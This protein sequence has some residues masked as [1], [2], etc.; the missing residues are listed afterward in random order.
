VVVLGLLLRVVGIHLAVI[1]GF[2]GTGGSGKT[3]RATH[4]VIEAA[5][6][7]PVG[8]IANF[9]VKKAGNPKRWNC[10]YWPHISP[11]G[12]ISAAEEW[13]EDERE[14]LCLVVVDESERY[15]QPRDWNRKGV[16]GP[17]SHARRAIE[18]AGLPWSWYSYKSYA[19]LRSDWIELLAMHR[20]LGFDFIF[21][22]PTKKMIDR[23]VMDMI[24]YRVDHRKLGRMHWWLPLVGLGGLHVAIARW[25]DF[26]RDSELAP[27]AN[28]FKIRKD[29]RARYD[30][31]A[32]RKVHFG[33]GLSAPAALP[34]APA[35]GWLLTSAGEEVDLR[36]GG[37]GLQA[38]RGAA[39]GGG[40]PPQGPG[41]T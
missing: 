11:R 7:R 4:R 24:E 22:A 8:V 38:A 23:Q 26:E 32:M 29:V 33:L 14:G 41:A 17:Y 9:S 10:V 25:K 16:D 37:N 12:L 27:E 1:E 18:G 34:A 2:F 31:L 21:T 19:E 39:V 40:S 6:K 13:A 20:H 36:F 3:Y 30:H 28:W 35:P 15:F 5:Q